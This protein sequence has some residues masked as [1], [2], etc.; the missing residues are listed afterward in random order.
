MR[1]AIAVLVVLS[2]SITNN[3]CAQEK[4][5]NPK[6][7]PSLFEIHNKALKKAEKKGDIKGPPP[8]YVVP[9]TLG[10]NTKPGSETQQALRQNEI[11]ERGS[12]G[13]KKVSKGIHKKK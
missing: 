1:Y 8:A 7:G 13:V 10:A 3:V 4:G 12:K 5:I 2:A 11:D 9:H 6:N